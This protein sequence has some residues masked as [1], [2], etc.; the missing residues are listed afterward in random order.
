VEELN[1]R[2]LPFAVADG[3]TNMATD[4][5]LLESAAAGVASLRFYQWQPPTL[6]LGYF[7]SAQVRSSDPLL[8]RLPW[9]RRPS[10]GDTL[11]HDREVTYALALPAGRAGQGGRACSACMHQVIVAA[12]AELGV[13][14]ELW[15]ATVTRPAE[16]PLCFHHVTPGD[17]M[18]AGAK[19]AGSAQRRQRGA[20]LQH[21]AV[22]YGTSRYTPLVPGIDQLT[23]IALS[24]AQICAGVQ[25]HWQLTE[26]GPLLAGALTPAEVER[27]AVL[28]RE[29]YASDRWNHRR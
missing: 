15:P 10:G 24:T 19:V 9:V 3:P 8:T 11:V 2:L 1:C 17:V 18:V 22:L 14:A 20:V 27:A 28:V 16:G 5:V 23:G 25:K 21:G 26:G 4:E 6:S 13:A 12:L 29:K 7:Q